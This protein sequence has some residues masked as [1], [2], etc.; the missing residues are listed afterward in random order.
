MRVALDVESRDLRRAHA[1]EGEAAFVM[2][3][4]QLF[5]WRFGL[6]Q[7]AEPAEGVGALVNGQRAFGNRLT[8]SAV[9]AVAAGDEIAGDLPLFARPL[10]ANLRRLTVEVA[11]AHILDIEE[12]LGAGVEPCLD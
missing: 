3:V 8:A 6:G 9:R 7:N 5:G 4:D 2:A 11:H 10:K 1:E 12:Y